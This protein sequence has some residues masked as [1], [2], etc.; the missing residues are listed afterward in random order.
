MTAAAQPRARVPKVVRKLLRSPHFVVGLALSAL[1]VGVALLAPWLAPKDPYFQDYGA[2][3]RPVGAE[4]F[5]LGTDQYGRDMLSRLIFGAR[6][7]V[8]VGPHRWAWGSCSACCSAC[9][10]A[11]TAAWTGPS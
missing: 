10:P 11:T 8:A 6:I 2:V 1:V 3:L 9:W 4:G 7:S 5:P